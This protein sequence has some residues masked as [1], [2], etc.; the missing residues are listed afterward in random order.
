[1][2]TR[3]AASIKLLRNTSYQTVFRM[4]LK[5]MAERSELEEDIEIP[6]TG[7]LK[8]ETRRKLGILLKKNFGKYKETILW[9][10]KKREHSKLS[11]FGTLTFRLMDHKPPKVKKQQVKEIQKVHHVVQQKKKLELDKEWVMTKIKVHQ[12]DGKVILYPN[13]TVFQVLFPDGTGQ[14]YYPSGNLAMLIFSVQARNFTYV[15]LEDS[16]KMWIR[17]LINNSGHATIYDENKDIWLCLSY[18]LGYY[19]IGNR[20]QKAWNWWN[21][22]LHTHAPPVRPITLEINQYIKIHIQSQDEISF[23]FIHQTKQI[24]LNLG[25]KYKYITPEALKE[26]KNKRVQEVEFSATA[27]KIQI[28]LGKMSKIRNLLTISDL[29][30]FVASAKDFL[31]NTCQKKKSEFQ[32][33]VTHL[34]IPELSQYLQNVS[35]WENPQEPEE[36]SRPV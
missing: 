35:G 4:M 18:N 33:V 26:M 32:D 29:E 9:I 3:R 23:Y 2:V 21:L 15:I 17:A 16:D 10:M 27:Q 24:H 30:N 22:N 28:L 8:S 20:S 1:M 6:M 12:G 14:I 25:T 11:E 31:G 19:F 36:N 34:T 13:G 5:E 7:H